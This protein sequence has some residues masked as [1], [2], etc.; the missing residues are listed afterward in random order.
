MQ[1]Q[2]SHALEKMTRDLEPKYGFGH[3]LRGWFGEHVD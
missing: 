3:G 2:S 1:A